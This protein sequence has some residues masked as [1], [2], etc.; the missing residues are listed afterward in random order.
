[1]HNAVYLKD[2]CSEVGKGFDL[3]GALKERYHNALERTEVCA[4][5]ASILDDACVPVGPVSGLTDTHSRLKRWWVELLIFLEGGGPFY[6][7]ITPEKVSR[8]LDGAA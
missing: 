4:R 8:V 1:M 6:I 3:R 7:F 2:R 5:P